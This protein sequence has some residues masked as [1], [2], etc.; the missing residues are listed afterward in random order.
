M[1]Q[2]ARTLLRQP[3]LNNK[4]A[5][6]KETVTLDGNSLNLEDLSKLGSGHANIKIA[7]QS[8]AKLQETRNVV[9]ELS[10]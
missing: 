8:W 4:L 2:K 3:I 1:L 7:E 9:D 6:I 5:S 10:A